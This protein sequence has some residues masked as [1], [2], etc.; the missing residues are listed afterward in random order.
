MIFYVL[1][2]NENLRYYTQVQPFCFRR[3]ETSAPIRIAI[4]ERF[5]D[6]LHLRFSSIRTSARLLETAEKSL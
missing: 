6:G 1:L 5:V 2:Y 3:L 4:Q